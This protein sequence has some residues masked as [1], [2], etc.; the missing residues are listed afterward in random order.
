MRDSGLQSLS[1]DVLVW[2]QRSTLALRMVISLPLEDLTE[3]R[4]G[5]LGDPS[6][7][8]ANYPPP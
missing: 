2:C 5:P 7:P 3:K 1:C 8:S 4:K 6:P